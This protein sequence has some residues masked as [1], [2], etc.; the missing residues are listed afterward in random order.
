ML[1]ALAGL[2]LPWVLVLFRDLPSRGVMLSVPVAYFLTHYFAWVGLSTGWFVNGRGFTGGVFSVFT[3]LSLGLLWIQRARWSELRRRRDLWVIGVVILIVMYGFGV[4]LRWLN[5]EISGTEKPM[6]FAFLNAVVRASEFPP[7]DPWFAGEPINYYYLGYSM[8]GFVVQLS[9]VDLSIGYN[10]A[11]ATLVAPGALA[12][13]SAGYDL[14]ALGGAAGR[15]R[16]AAAALSMVLVVLAGNLAVIREMFGSQADDDLGFWQGI[17]WNASR[18]IQHEDLS[19]LTDYTINEFPAFSFILGDLHPHVMSLPFA[20]LAVS[21]AVQWMV[22]AG[23]LSMS[24]R[25]THMLSTVLTGLFLVGLYT[26]NAWD[27][28]TFVGLVLVAGLLGA[29]RN[30]ARLRSVVPRM[31]LAIVLGVLAWLPYFRHYIPPS[32]GMGLVQVRSDALDYLQVF[33]LFLTAVIV[34]LGL[35]VWDAPRDRRFLVLLLGSGIAAV[36]IGGGEIVAGLMALFVLSGL[37]LWRRKS[38]LTVAPLVW[39]VTSGLALLVIAEL[40]FLDDFFAV[41]YE[42]MNTVFKLHY[43]SWGLL[44]V[45]AGPGLILVWRRLSADSGSRARFGRLIF[46]CIFGLLAIPA[47]TYPINAILMKAEASPV[48]GS[49]DGLASARRHRMSDVIVAEWLRDHAPRDA[50][51]LEA[52]GRAYSSDSRMSTW[53]GVP[54]VIGWIQHEEL[55]RRSDDRIA[56][57]EADVNTVYEAKDP[58]AMR[59]VLDRY[60]VTHVIVG[61]SERERYG[62]ESVER[63]GQYFRTVLVT[64]TTRVFEVSREA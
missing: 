51:I 22:H 54:T 58:M 43:Q 40:V 18:T 46:A 63:L 34:T 44:G 59:A 11:L 31:I 45:A 55:W 15:A 7:M 36:V 17:G 27:V 49:L 19:G 2:G 50:V 25:F 53:S 12:A 14:A 28:P 6:D 41:P 20:L 62:H 5:P 33:G 9:G 16:L 37:V 24:G 57:R 1:L 32:H 61:D 64:G 47:L 8:A 35:L 23:R 21:L 10:L 38:D 52:P 26:L 42:R 3:I 29:G 60:A 56:K 39:L 30:S 4:A 13:A 48:S